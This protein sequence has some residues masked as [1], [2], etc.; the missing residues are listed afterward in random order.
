[1]P[2]IEEHQL[3]PWGWEN[4]PEEESL[5]FSSMDY[6]AACTYNSYALFFKLQDEERPKALA[7]LRE[8]LE[9]TLA[10]CR[11]LVG[12]IEKNENDDDHSFVKRRDSTVK[13]VVKYWE[14]EDGV[15]SLSDVENAHFAS[16]SLGDTGRFVVEGMAYGE[17]PECLPS[18]KPVVSAF[19]ANFVPGGSS[20][21]S[22]PITTPTT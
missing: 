17:K 12:T 9:K 15:P 8:G 14:A 22:T 20:L 3:R 10:Q 19:Q 18:A 7:V 21:S 1:M 2:R 4:D 13:F 5:R 6:L 11:Q 16:S